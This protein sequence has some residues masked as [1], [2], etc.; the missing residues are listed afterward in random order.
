MP[1]IPRPATGMH[2]RVVRNLNQSARGK[3]TTNDN[4]G[5]ITP[6]EYLGGLLRTRRYAANILAL[7]RDIKR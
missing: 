6:P 5:Q 3:C 2:A 1:P 4:D 7:A